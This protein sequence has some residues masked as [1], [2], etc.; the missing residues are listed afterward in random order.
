MANV[1]NDKGEVLTIDFLNDS[2]SF[3][4]IMNPYIENLKRLGVV[5][6]L[7]NVDPAQATERQKKYDYDV[8]VQRFVMSLTPGIELRGIFGSEAASK[9]GG[10]NLSGVESPA[11]DALLDHI[12]KAQTRT[13]LD[14]AVR[15]LDRALRAMHIW[16]PQWYKASHNVAYL[17]V[18]E[19]PEQLPPYAMGEMDFWWYNAEK[20]EKLREQGALR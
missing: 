5:A 7:Q 20:A 2:P 13:E 4:R 16:V 19:H 11:I 15:A 14:T 10:S 17:D 6:Q 9:E 3:E 8:V 1:Q 18:F 12:E